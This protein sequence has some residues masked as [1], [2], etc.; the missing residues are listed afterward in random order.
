[1][2]E[3]FEAS[4]DYAQ[5]LDQVDILYSFRER[6]HFPKHE[7]RDAYYFCGNSLGLQPKS[8]GYLINSELEDWATYG[9]EGHFRARNPWFSYHQLFS[10]RLARVVGAKK[11]EVVAMNT[12]T[13][14]LH[15]LMMSFYR[16]E[17]GRYKI[18]M[19]AGAFPSDQYALETQVRMYGY[20]PEDA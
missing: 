20:N 11:H 1:M 17:N 2:P 3:Q 4:L 18:L 10:E 9:V 14:N 13:V 7:D 6:F 8:V 19:E 15:L 5:S 16:P 12:L